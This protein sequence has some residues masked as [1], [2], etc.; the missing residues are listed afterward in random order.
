MTDQ[1]FRLELFESR[2]ILPVQ[3]LAPGIHLFKIGEPAGNSLI[4]T[5]FVQYLALGA[6]VKVNYFDFGP[7][8]GS[9]PGERIDLADHPIVSA[10]DDPK[11][12]RRLIS[13][14]S[15]KPMLE[16]IV[17]G[18][19]AE[20]GVHIKVV[21]D[22]PV[23]QQ[24]GG[25]TE[26]FTGAVTTS[27]TAIPSVI[28]EPILSFEVACPLD[29]ANNLLASLDGSVWHDLAPSDSFSW[30]V[31]GENRKQIFVK[32]KAGNS[33]YHLIVTRRS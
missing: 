7:G 9:G 24:M 3:S 8:S 18:G 30:S 13:H 17:I 16:V 22:F 2:V 29:S 1:N 11:S 6:S 33:D 12:D 21:D 25:R 28:G 14:V 20:I 19:S 5:V 31:E 32:A 23:T 4:S 27:S 26:Q 10:G 15:N